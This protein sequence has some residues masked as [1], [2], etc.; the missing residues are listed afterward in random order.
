MWLCFLAR[1]QRSAGSES[2]VESRWEQWNP[3][4]V[5]SWMQLKAW[6]PPTD[7]RPTITPTHTHTHG[8]NT[9]S[10]LWGTVCPDQLRVGSQKPPPEWEGEEL[11]WVWSLWSAKARRLFLIV[12]VSWWGWL[13]RLVLGGFQEPSD[14]FLWQVQSRLQP[15]FYSSVD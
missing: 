10:S 5:S 8:T 1:G 7:P 6:S 4:D 3:T 15:G 2:M 12:L 14:T 11:L 9:H 13:V